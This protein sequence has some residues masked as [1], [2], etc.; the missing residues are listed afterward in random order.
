MEDLVPTFFAFIPSAIRGGTLTALTMGGVL[1]SL[2]FQHYKIKNDNKGLALSLIGFSILLFILFFLTRPYWGLSK[3]GATPAWLFL[4]SAF[5]ILAFLLSYWL[6]DVNQKEN[7]FAI[8]YPAGTG[9]L[10]CYLIP[11]FAY[12]TTRLVGIELPEQILN[13][14]LGLIKS[15]LFALSCAWLTGLLMKFN[16][17]LKV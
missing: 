4:C 6:I 10:L 16:V 8:V 9:T 3:L 11:Y 12:A 13:G 1:T 17:R 2:I 7:W 14:G 5:T 15:F